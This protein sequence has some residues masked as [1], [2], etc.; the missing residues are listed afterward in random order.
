M[1]AVHVTLR[2]FTE[3]EVTEFTRK[4]NIPTFCV[5]FLPFETL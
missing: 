1:D 5:W 3:F 2:V 4:G